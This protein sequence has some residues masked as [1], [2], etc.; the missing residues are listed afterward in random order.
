MPKVKKPKRPTRRAVWCARVNL[1]NFSDAQWA[2]R[3][4]WS[5]E[6]VER[7]LRE[8]C[9]VLEVEALYMEAQTNG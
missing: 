6:D 9:E 2:K 1:G 8:S 5:A 4:G 7:V 3:G